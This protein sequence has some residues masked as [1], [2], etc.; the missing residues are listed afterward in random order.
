M[1]SALPGA[2]SND[3][4]GSDG[5]TDSES[6]AAVTNGSSSGSEA[7]GAR[8][9]GYYAEIFLVCFAALLLEV[10]Y[11][12]IIS[13]KLFYY[14]TYLIIGLALLGIGT[15]GVLMTVSTR[16]KRASTDGI[17]LWGSLLAALT[18][19]VGYWIVARQ[20]ISSLAL[21][22]YGTRASV[23]N[24]VGLLV[25]CLAIFASFIAVG[26]IIATLFSRRTEGIGRLYFADLTGAGLACVVVVYLLGSIGPPRTVFLAAAVFAATG[27]W[28]AVQVRA[29]LVAL[30]GAGLTGALVLGVLAP[31]LVPEVRNDDFKNDVDNAASTS[32]SPIF[33]VDAVDLGDQ[34]FLQHDGL[35]GSVI[36]RWD[37]ELS[38]LDELAFDE[39]ERSFPFATP[40][41]EPDKVMIIGAAGGH[42]ILASLYFEASQIDAIELNP[43][44]FELVTDTYED[45][46]GNLADQPGVN[47]VNGDGRSFLARSDDAYDLIWY[48]A[49]DSYAAT[50]AAQA[51][52]FVLSESYLYTTETVTET[53]EHLADDGILAA[54]FGE[55]EY[56]EKPN[57]TARYASTVREALEDLGVENPAEHVLVATTG[58]VDDEGNER[59]FRYSSILVKRTPFTE[60][61]IERFT[62]ATEQVPHTRVEY[63]PGQPADDPI[64]AILTL[65]GDA[66]D[67][68]YAQYPYEVGPISDESPF[69][70][71]FESFRDVVAQIGDPIN[72]FDPEDSIGERVLLLLL[73]IAIVFA[74]VFLL[75][76]FVKVRKVWMALP[77]KGVSFVYFAA[78]G[79]GFMLFEISL[80]QRLILFLGYPTYSLTVTLASILVFTGVGAYLSGRYRQQPERAVRFLLP[81]IVVL[82][83]GY[84]FGLPALTDALLSW[85]IGARLL[86]TF[87][88]L[89]PL[90]V[91]LGTFMPVGLG[92]VSGLSEHGS[93][94]VAWGWAVNGF[95]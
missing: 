43:A 12:R 82:T 17:L 13:F 44:T 27:L 16:L 60:E 19:A 37:G 36:R 46:A 69:F 53:Y 78:L 80:I 3:S 92:V 70:W 32:W 62:E 56:D 94:Y 66:L 20:R 5:S 34:L 65:E 2:G 67:D 8:T 91:C 81:A 21:W 72:P 55:V 4:D 11:T 52:A 6:Q 15:G 14:Y 61:E 73:A 30:A 23:L 83:V 40:E 22:D 29:R 42:E 1:N 51:G 88:V 9:R 79:L 48:P 18:T 33:R 24:V 74:A 64:S 41:E 25:I 49:P 90:G 84:L 75:L 63:A 7:A 35:T 50:N 47:Y 28:V 95:A 26:V 31:S 59:A 68:W 76:P 38:S 45:Y 89:A 93:E 86:I 58:T 87:V 39:N 57:R 54:Q 77:R 10:S 71:H 85:P